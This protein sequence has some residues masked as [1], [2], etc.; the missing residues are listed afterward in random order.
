MI[1]PFG[2]NTLVFVVVLVTGVMFLIG[3]SVCVY[4]DGILKKIP[5]AAQSATVEVLLGW[6]ST[7][8]SDLMLFILWLFLV[9]L[10]FPL[11]LSVGPVSH[12]VV[13]LN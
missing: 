7:V 3:R 12:V 10:S 5:V 13:A 4:F 11:F 6:A 8:D 1:C 2:I 9:K